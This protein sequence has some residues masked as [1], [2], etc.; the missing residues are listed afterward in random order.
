MTDPLLAQRSIS[1]GMPSGLSLARFDAFGMYTRLTA[2]GFHDEAEWCTRTATAALASGVNATS[3]SIPAVLRP[4]LRCVTCRTLTSVLA[5]DRSISFCRFLTRGQSC[6]RAAAKI[7]CRSRRTCSSCA[8]Q[9]TLSHWTG[10]LR[11]WSSGPFTIRAASTA[12][13]ATA[14]TTHRP[15]SHTGVEKL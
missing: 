9:S 11:G 10:A 7:R 4:V 12:T 5:R 2:R 3:P 1:T 13:S 14:G 15:P 6:S 8:R